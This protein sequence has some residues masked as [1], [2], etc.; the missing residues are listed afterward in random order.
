MKIVKRI[1]LLTI[2]SF[3]WAQT[4]QWTGRTHGELDWTTIE[5]KH[6][7]IHH[8]QGIESIALE[9]AS[10]AEQVRPLLL[11]QMDLEDI[12]TI[13][14]I[15]TT[16]DEIMNG[17]ALWTYTTFIWVDQNDAAIWLENEKWLY[18]VLAHELQ[19]IV[20]FH[21]VK[22][23]LPEPWSFLYSKI[24][25]WAVEGLA[26]YETERWRPYRSDINHKFHVLKNKMDEMDP[27][28]DGYS[29]LLYWSE[30]FGDSTIVNTLAERNIFGL[31]TFEK[32]FKKHTGITV[33]QFNEDWRRH[34]NTYYY[35]YRAQK[36]AIDEI[37]KV[38]TLPI[39]K[40]NA[41]HFF[42]DSTQIAII[43]RDDEDQ[44][45]QSLFVIQ[46][47]TTQ[48]KKMRA[49]RQKAL[50]K[51]KAK[52]KDK[53]KAKDEEPGFFA[54]LFGKDKK[55]EK[56]KPKPILVWDKKEVDYGRF[57]RTIQWS[58]NGRKILYSKY[59]FGKNQS[60]VNDVKVYN[61][62]TEKSVWL[63]KSM[64]ATYPDWAPDGENIIFVAHENSIAN[65]YTMNPDGSNINKITDYTYDT[66]ILNPHYSPDGQSVIFAMADQEANLDLFLLDVMSGKVN[67]ITNNPAADYD[68]V[69][70]PG[71][72]YIS[73]T[74]HAGSTPNI[75][76]VNL[77]TGDTKQVSDVGDAVWAAQWSVVDS[78]I[79]AST[80]SDV[81]TVRIVNVDPHREITT[82][83]LVLRDKYTA[84][85]NT[86]PSVLLTGIDPKKYVDIVKSH[87]YTPLLGIK[88][89]TSLVLPLGN[90]II[91]M[92]QWTDAMI[93][94]IVVG[95][96]IADFSEN[97]THRFLL[98][99]IN[100]MGGPMWGVNILSLL[101]IKSKPY[102][103]SKWGL[104]EENNSIAFWANLPFNAG[105]SMSSNH[106]FG[107][108]LKITDRN[109][110]VIKGI[111]DETNGYIIADT[112]RYLPIPVSGTEG[113]VSINY[114]WKNK[115]PHKQNF[116]IPKHGF[117]VNVQLDVASSDVVGDFDFT[118]IITDAFFNL[119]PHKKSPIV[120][121]GRIKTVTML[122]D[123]PPPQ[124]LPAITN[125]TPI[126]LAG[127][128]ILGAD[129]V[130]H[131]RGWDD[132]RLGDR[133][134]FGT[135]EPRIGNEKVTIAAFLDFGNAW[136]GDG[137]MDDWLFTGGYEIRVNLL[138]LV[139]AYGTAQDF[140]RWRDNEVPTNYLRL[141]L[142]NPF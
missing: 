51:I 83:D 75:H 142:V 100:A 1:I 68:P 35:G 71:G 99:Y 61:L 33:E 90:S 93:R 119:L 55:D 58:P 2:V 31:F 39:K 48:E 130:V 89:L 65:L 135:I 107:V 20:F 111:D 7:R 45:D 27:H 14:I 95:V 123:N 30:R 18:Q 92:T 114:T 60:L 69:W 38:V 25:G 125:D 70:H 106:M 105:N 26:E 86:E 59:H 136:Y 53:D 113:L 43:G 77:S 134:V 54:K 16:E 3:S 63:T 108:S 40:I 81:D 11:K 102:D 117:G 44:F 82:K 103:R 23:W 115:R 49:K 91:G 129:E 29:K 4:W 85:R 12:P 112:T 141:S 127:Y 79:M 73:Y 140:N 133:L 52:A 67:R 110:T 57:H 64:R 139:M 8:H 74:S 94:H 56:K 97:N 47:D 72:D 5:T 131:L 13:D 9:G 10:M 32:A 124:D 122:G 21:K 24:P 37:G 126:Y 120:V 78:T 116:M 88:H 132:W 41:F 109:T 19:H 118:R 138:G 42:K 137:E 62:D 104:L 50:E 96:G 87:D 22:T 28:H 36:E 17:F 121:F 15:F 80:L 76:T 34:M 6:F 101:D 84:W 66:Q 128:N 46:R 98:Q